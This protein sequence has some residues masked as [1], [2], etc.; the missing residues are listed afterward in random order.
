M[1]L[2]IHNKNKLK[3][4]IKGDNDQEK[5]SAVAHFDLFSE[6]AERCLEKK[7]FKNALK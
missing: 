6:A 5:G 4:S 3:K 2:V 1:Y 7:R